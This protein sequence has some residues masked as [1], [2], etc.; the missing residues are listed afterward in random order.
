MSLP[1]KHSLVKYFFIAILGICVLFYS[2]GYVIIYSGLHIQFKEAGVRKIRQYATNRAIK[3]FDFINSFDSLSIVNKQYLNILKIHKSVYYGKSDDFMF[4]KKHEVK[5]FGKLFDI[6]KQK[7][8]GDTIYFLCISD[9]NED[10][11][12]KS[13]L[14]HYFAEKGN[15]SKSQPLKNIVEKL[16]FDGYIDEMLKLP[17]IQDIS[18]E[19]PHI[20]AYPLENVLDIPAPPP[21]NFA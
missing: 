11:L 19:Y 2:F 1:I 18:K 8:V 15:N 5:Y 9:K 3:N 16:H 7:Q 13:F 14:E 6:I 17:N 20:F 4:I 12:E 21:K 10:M